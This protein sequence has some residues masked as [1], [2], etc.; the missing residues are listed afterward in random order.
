MATL[1]SADVSFNLIIAGLYPQGVAIQGFAAD[2]ILS[3]ATVKPAETSMGADAKFSSGWVPV[4]T[5]MDLMLQGD[6]DSNLIFD[7]WHAA[8]Q[9]IKGN[10]LATAVIAFTQNNAKFNLFQGVL[11]GIQP[12]GA[13]K[14]IMS[15]RPYQIT[16]GQVIR[17][18]V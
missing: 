13:A 10:Y 16:W 5:P 7:A 4:E 17:V 8:Q 6:S 15:P 11:T 14:K 12:M 1:T 9:V 18:P 2:D 3:V